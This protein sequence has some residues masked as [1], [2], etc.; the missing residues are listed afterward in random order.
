[1]YKEGGQINKY[2]KK[3]YKNKDLSGKSV[4]DIGCGLGANADFMQKRGA[5]VV[6]IDKDKDVRPHKICDIMEYE[7]SRHFDIILCLNVLQFLSVGDVK[8]IL[9]KILRNS[10]TIILQTFYTPTIVELLNN[11]IINKFDNFR[12]VKYRHWKC[13]DLRPK[14][15]THDCVL[16][17]LKKS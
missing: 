4:L 3:T 16:W 15:H 13:I 7:F 11:I 8:K 12:L 2:L 1:M 5:E 17:V 6:K 14:P 9:P 10:D